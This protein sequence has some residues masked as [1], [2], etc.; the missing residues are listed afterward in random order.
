MDF[1]IWVSNNNCRVLKVWINDSNNNNKQILKVEVI[2][3]IITRFLKVWVNND[4]NNNN[5][6]ILKFGLVI[7][8]MGF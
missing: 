1:E 7:I 2:I 8:I 6:Q 3:I 4:K 5:K